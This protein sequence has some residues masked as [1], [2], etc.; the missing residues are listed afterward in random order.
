ME[1]FNDTF[2]TLLWA[3]RFNKSREFLDYLRSYKPFIGYLVSNDGKFIN[4]EL[5]NM[6]K[7]AVVDSSTLPF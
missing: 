2:V 4:D 5:G 3:F 6:W 1:M 7:E